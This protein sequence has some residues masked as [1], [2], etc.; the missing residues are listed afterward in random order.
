[1]AHNSYHFTQL[2]IASGTL[3]VDGN[4]N[5]SA[6]KELSGRINT[7]VKAVGIST[8]VPLNV[9]GTVESPLLY[10]TGATIAGAALGTAIMGPGVGTSVGAKVGGWV[11]NMLGGNKTNH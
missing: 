11:D 8:E 9:T 2:K 3:A 4:V 7:Q 1:M 6:K 10:P 5:I